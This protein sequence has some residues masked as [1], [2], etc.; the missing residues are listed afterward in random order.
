MIKDLN[1]R[2]KIS[3]GKTWKDIGNYF[4]NKT[5]FAQEIKPKVEK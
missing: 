3:A 4:L 2:S 1:V 5:S